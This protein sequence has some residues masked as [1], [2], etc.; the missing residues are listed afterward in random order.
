MWRPTFRKTH[1]LSI[2]TACAL[3]IANAANAATFQNGEFITY[4]Q[5]SWGDASSAAGTLLT[6]NFNSVYGATF[7][8][9]TVGL[10]TTG[11]TMT[12]DAP[13]AVFNYLP[14]GGSP[15]TLNG[16]VF[17]PSSTSSGTFGGDVLA[18]QL[19]VDFSNAGFLPRFLSAR[20]FCRTSAPCRASTV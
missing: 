9:V 19:N 3:L 8:T 18:L 10:P 17:N 15:G 13:T 4:P 2:V 1:V 12:I 11:F 16:N 6:A 7:D 20:S 5:G 14:A